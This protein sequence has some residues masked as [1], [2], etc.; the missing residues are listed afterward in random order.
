MKKF[1]LAIV[2]TTTRFVVGTLMLVTPARPNEK[3]K[4]FQKIPT[5]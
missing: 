3:R 1:I 2:Q 5:L 4:T